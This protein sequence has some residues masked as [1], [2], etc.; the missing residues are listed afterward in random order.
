MVDSSDET[1]VR[2]AVA[3]ASGYAGGEV[4]R[5]LLG[6]P[7]LRDGRLEI[8][9]LTAGAN[10]GSTL[11]EHQPHLLPLADRV[12]APTT[13]EE[14]AGHDVVFLGLPHGRSAALAATLPEST[15]IIDCGADFRL[16][17]AG[18]WTRYYG[19]EHAG[20][21][22]Y[23][24]PE[25]PGG[26]DALRGARRIAVPGCYP[27]VASVA[28]APALA[29]GIVEPAVRV[30]AVSGTSGAGRKLD[31]GL[32]GSEVMGSVRAYNIAGAHRHTPEIAQNLAAANGAP[33]SVSF[34]P[35]LAPMPR[36]ILATCTAPVR[37][38]AAQARAVYEKAYANEPFV[39][40]LPE[41]A[42]PQTGS[43]LGSNAITLQVTV[44]ADAGLLV[45]IGAV[46]NLTKGTAGAA[47]QS[48]NLALGFDEAEGLSTVGVAP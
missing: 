29:A 39:H 20:S 28:L 14:L 43:V 30:V 48:M 38:D 44:D 18:A 27:T 6:H 8:G 22:P 15:V 7:R 23:G 40:L 47:V 37:V 34:T 31:V 41:G 3:G 26:R 21:W 42:L 10:A 2:V 11:G 33:V 45:V 5:L 12:L 46:D 17:D 9:A 1:R 24:L 35:V 36:G 16:R 32:L 4:L 19:T 25:L 13:A